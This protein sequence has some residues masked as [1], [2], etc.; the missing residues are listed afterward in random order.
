MQCNVARQPSLAGDAGDVDIGP[1]GMAGIGEVG[2]GAEAFPREPATGDDGAPSVGRLAGWHDA[3]HEFG[4]EAGLGWQ[5]RPL[6]RLSSLA[7]RRTRSST[8]V[9]W[10]PLAAG[11]GRPNSAVG[12]IER[13]ISPS[14]MPASGRPAARIGVPPKAGG[15]GIASGDGS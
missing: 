5:P 2:P 11:C 9:G 1:R 13:L 4:V 8:L 12:A 10:L 15:L 7:S 3:G 14:R 6:P